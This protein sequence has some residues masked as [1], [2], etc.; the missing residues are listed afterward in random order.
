MEAPYKFV[1]LQIYEA[2]LRIFNHHSPTRNF[3][4][5]SYSLPEGRE[6]IISFIH[7]F[8]LF[9]SS[10]ATRVFEFCVM[11]DSNNQ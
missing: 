9:V 8:C 4:N 2:Q 7:F 10:V 3:K 5:S 6:D 1:A 11:V